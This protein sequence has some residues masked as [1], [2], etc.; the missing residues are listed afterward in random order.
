MKGFVLDLRS[1]PGGLLDVAVE[2]GSRLI[3]SG[4]I[5]LIQKNGRLDPLQVD[6]SKQ[7]H[8]FYPM[9]VLINGM[10]ASASEILSGAIRDHKRGTIIGT[11]SYGKGLVQTIINLEDGSAVSITTA[12][13]LTPNHRDVNKEK[14]HPDIVIKPTEEQMKKGDDVQLKKGLEVVREKLG[15]RD[16]SDDAKN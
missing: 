13:Y 5:V 4:D 16:T 1:N 3:P 2:I 6:V 10:S 12:R 9:A 7:N 11:D 8:K 15:V 14:I